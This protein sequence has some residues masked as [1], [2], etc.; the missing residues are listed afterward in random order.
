[1]A[2]KQTRL[3]RKEAAEQTRARLLEAGARVLAGEGYFGATVEDIAEA[4]G[5][6][7][8]AFYAHFTDKADLLLTLMEE[9]NRVGLDDL[10]TRLDTETAE[11]SVDTTVQWFLDR[12][13]SPSA[14]DRAIAEFG[15]SAAA[16]PAHVARLRR[17]VRQSRAR[18]ATMT[19]EGFARADMAPP[20]DADRFAAMVIALVEGFASLQR[21]DPDGV[22]PDALGEAIV[23]LGE[24]AIAAADRAPSPDRAPR[25]SPISGA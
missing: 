1:M 15:A 22:P 16:Q 8:G 12:F 6:T 10:E 14:L 23:Y 13:T 18:V 4:A 25:H 20:V 2:V 21:L 3:S 9:Q 19:E 11:G 7:R 5:Y 24:G 17:H